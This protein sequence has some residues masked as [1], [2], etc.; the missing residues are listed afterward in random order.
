[1]AKTRDKG[2]GT[3]QGARLQQ[4]V[5]RYLIVR[6]PDDP[7]V[8]DCYAYPEGYGEPRTIMG[9][10]LAWTLWAETAAAA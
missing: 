6:R 8:S 10:A 2:Q 7:K 1:M 3:G 9:C 5:T 4:P